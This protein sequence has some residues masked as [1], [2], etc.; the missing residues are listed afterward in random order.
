[1]DDLRTYIQISEAIPGWTRGEDAEEVA[2]VSLS[3]GP[4]AVMVEI[5]AFLGSST[6]LL[7]GPRRL[8]GSGKVHVVD[9]FDCSGD[10]F[11]IPY[12]HQILESMGGGSP[13]SHFE[14]NI[15]EAGLTDWVEVHQGR[16]REI[17][18]GW[19]APIDLLLLD[20]DQ[21]PQGAREAYESWAPF[22][23]PGGVIVL[24]N[25]RP[26]EYAESHDGHRRLVLE[27]IV[28]PSYQE[29]RQVG[30]TTFAR[31][32]TPSRDSPDG[33]PTE[34]LS[35]KS[36]SHLFDTRPMR[37][38]LYAQC[39]NDEFMLPF[40]FR[41]YDS[42]VDRYIIFDD[43]S[44]DRSLSLLSNHPGVEVRRFER[45]DLK[46]FAISEQALSNECWKESRGIAD[47]VIVTD[48]DEHLFHPSMPRYLRECAVAG[49]TII[50]SLGFQMISNNVPREGEVL[51][52]SYPY[53]VPWVQMMKSSIFDPSRIE[54]INFLLG[55][56]AA[57]PAGE[58]RIPSR[59]EVLLLHYKYLNL[60]RTHLRHSQLL[61]RLGS[62]DLQNRWGHKYG[63][64]LEEL[65]KDWNDVLGAA[66]DVRGFLGES[67]DRYPLDRWWK[68]FARAAANAEGETNNFDPYASSTS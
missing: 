23:K 1:M 11:S 33:R 55:R 67:A 52:Q 16:A 68:K 27:E 37:V 63:W 5:G 58:I 28:P 25:T 36:A 54:E 53:G 9:P 24:R 47:W 30:A 46:S 56:H 39:W 49:V 44:T 26:R 14:N 43:G 8:R 18:M 7:A 64:S 32:V 57:E 42:F 6:V 4:D 62:T 29:I 3:L 12:Y 59:D 2:R 38:H 45:F 50:P 20:G 66:V 60:E 61:S 65:K 22:L 15:R 34:S 41:H 19:I 51:F 10:S 21:S 40:F 17:A 48:I 35:R 13:R 31:K